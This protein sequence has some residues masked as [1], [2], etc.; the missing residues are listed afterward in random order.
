MPHKGLAKF[1]DDGYL[2]NDLLNI[3]DMSIECRN[4]LMDNCLS[5]VKE[6]S[7]LIKT[8]SI[9]SDELTIF[10]HNT[11]VASFASSGLTLK[12]M[13]LAGVLHSNSNGHITTSLINGS[14]I[15]SNANIQNSSLATLTASNL[16]ANSA[17]TATSTL[18]PNT[19]VS[20]DEFG[21]FSAGIITACE[22][23]G[24]FNNVLPLTGGT[25]TGVLNAPIIE[26]NIIQSKKIDM[27]IDNNTILSIK[28]DGVFINGL[29]G[30][31]YASN[32][33]L[34]NKLINTTDIELK[35]ISN[36]LLQPIKTPN[37]IENSS[38]TATS[39]LIPNSIVLR[40]GAGGFTAGTITANLNGT[41]SN[42]LLLS[43]GTLSGTLILPD[44]SL[45]N[46]SITFSNNKTAGICYSNGFHLF[47]NTI[48][49]SI[50]PNG[51]IQLPSCKIGIVHCDKN[52]ILSSSLIN[53]SDIALDASIQNSSLATLTASNLVANSATTA[54]STLVPNTIVSRDE[55][56]NFTAG[57]IIATLA[58]LASDNLP[59]SGGTLTGP[60]SVS[61]I[62]TKSLELD[63]DMILTTFKSGIVKSI[64]GYLSTSL[65]DLTSDVSS[66]LPNARTSATSALIPNSIV[67]R[68]SRGSFTANT[69]TGNFI[70]TL[71]G[72][73]NGCLAISGGIMNG[74]IV[75]P[76]G[77]PYNPSLRFA[78]ATLSGLYSNL[79]SINVSINSVEVAQFDSNGLTIRTLS[80]GLVQALNGKLHTTN[81]VPNELTS[82][83]SYCKSNTIVSRNLNGTFE[84]KTLLLHKYI[85]NDDDCKLLTPYRGE[86]TRNGRTF[87]NLPCGI[88]NIE[89]DMEFHIDDTI[90]NTSC[91]VEIQL[92][93]II[94]VFNNGMIL[95][96][97]MSI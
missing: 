70:G 24:T 20:R 36:D 93:T 7:K 8:N 19:I 5:Y 90:Y 75:L 6:S 35:S 16:V 88:Y 37:L 96:M 40:D 18:T 1:D 94:T 85:F 52:G 63:T 32:G 71:N 10:A 61:K 9:Y 56:G 38:T 53:G 11:P 44:G 97:F 66:I 46:A 59:L 73:A 60:L 12:N 49:L 64:N 42:C 91:I 23:N 76:A 27:S 2:I 80:N 51:I 83:T 47:N 15:A 41:A 50:L 34:I 68:D 74:S 25:L 54:T 62:T 67:M 72:V 57:V 30:V 77:A 92:N 86:L 22:F 31:V 48:G 82:A 17:T 89:T 33:K 4:L 14:D 95:F 79:D 65:I 81:Q 29:N 21:N 39:A 55:F 69:I 28:N 84:Y 3:N 87:T 78:G 58:G 43:G 13:L 45:N 26:T